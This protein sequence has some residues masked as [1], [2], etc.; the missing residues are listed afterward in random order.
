M[1][2]NQIWE[3]LANERPV[4]LYDEYIGELSFQKVT[5]VISRKDKNGIIH[6][7]AELLDKN[8]TSVVIASPKK[9]RYA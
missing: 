8:G 1:Q 7:S 5:A 4:K 3:A 6:H 2:A 9:I